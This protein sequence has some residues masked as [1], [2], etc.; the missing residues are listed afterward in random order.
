MLIGC[1]VIT[2]MLCDYGHGG[3]LLHLI[4]SISVNFT[5]SCYHTEYL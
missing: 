3:V 4:R 1:F 5:G 2:V